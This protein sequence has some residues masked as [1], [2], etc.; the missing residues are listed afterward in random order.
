MTADPMVYDLLEEFA[1]KN[2]LNLTSAES[3]LWELLRDRKL[4]GYEFRRQHIIGKYIAD[5]ICIQ[6][7]LIIEID[8]LFH[9]LPENKESD[10]IRTEWLE[11]IGFKVIRFTNEQVFTDSTNVLQKIINVSKSLSFGEVRIGKYG[12]LKRNT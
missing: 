8:G 1:N 6:N 9:Q 11:S 3:A 4:N 10:E 2:R 12:K 5:F 7:K